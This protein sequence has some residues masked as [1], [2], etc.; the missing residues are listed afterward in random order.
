MNMDYFRG[1]Q[2]TIIL[3]IISN[4][5]YIDKSCDDNSNRFGDRFIRM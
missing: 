2:Y 4:V 1:S 5:W 3:H